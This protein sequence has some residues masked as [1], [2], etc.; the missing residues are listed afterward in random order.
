MTDALKKWDSLT[1]KIAKQ[2]YVI[3]SSDKTSHYYVKIFTKCLSKL[4]LVASS[5]NLFLGR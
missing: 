5:L 2:L 1:P 4:P 3:E